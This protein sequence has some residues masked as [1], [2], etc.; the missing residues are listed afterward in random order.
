MI[1]KGHSGFGLQVKS[2][3]VIKWTRGEDSIPILR[4]SYLK[5]MKECEENKLG[6]I[7]T[8]DIWSMTESCGIFSFSMP[9]MDCPTGFTDD[10]NKLKIREQIRRSLFFRS[11]DIRLG[12]KKCVLKELEGVEDSEFK[13]IIESLLETC[14]D[15]Y[16]YGYAHGDFGFANMLVEEGQIHMIDF[17][18]SFINSPLLD[19][20]TLE[21]SIFCN[22][23]KPWHIDIVKTLEQDH[24]DF[25][26]HSTI[27]RMTKVLKY[28]I[29]EKEKLT[30]FYGIAY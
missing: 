23:A 3:Q 17:T 15:Y 11:R 5:Q 4:A 16:P 28:K 14:S 26:L 1:H 13:L 22:D 6:V 2:G 18:E 21:M 29:T 27:I 8:V 10:K 7:K 20:A 12:F 30:L 19:V 24:W 25:R 9:H